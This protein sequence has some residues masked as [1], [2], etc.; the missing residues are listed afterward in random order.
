VNADREV[1]EDFL[2]EFEAGVDVV[3]GG[4]VAG[5]SNPGNGGKS[6][7]INGEGIIG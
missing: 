5:I 7:F 4:T 6:Q 1:G 3:E 2:I